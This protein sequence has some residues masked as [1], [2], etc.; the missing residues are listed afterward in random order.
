M[1]LPPGAASPSAP[2]PPDCV[3]V[4]LLRGTR[5]LL[6]LADAD[7]TLRW[8]NPAL[9]TLIGRDL[10]QLVG[11]TWPEALP[12]APADRPALDRLAASLA[13]RAPTAQPGPA[14]EIE[15]ELLPAAAAPAWLRIAAHSVLNDA[16]HP[17]GATRWLLVMHDISQTRQSQREAKRLSGLLDMAQEFGRI[18]VWERDIPSGAGRW[19][20][21]VFDFYGLDPAA[22]TPTHAEAV[23]HLHPDDRARMNYLEST[24]R[25]GR[26]QLRYR[27]LHANG[28]TRWIQSQWEVQ[29]SPAGVPCRAVGILMDDSEVVEQA[30]ALGAPGAQLKLAIDL[31]H[32]AIWRHDLRTDRVHYNDDAQRVLAFPKSPDGLSLQET[33]DRIHPDDVG[34]VASAARHALD[35]PDRPTDIEARFNAGDGLWRTLLTRRVLERGADGTPSAWV[36]IALDVSE[37]ADERRRTTAL[38]Q[39]MEAAA[40]AASVGIWSYDTVTH[41]AQWNEPMFALVGRSPLLGAPSRAE[42]DEQVIHPA[43][44]D[45]MRAERAVLDARP[46][47]GGEQRYRVALPGGE[48][49]WLENRVRRETLDGHLTILGVTLD[50]TDRQLAEDA[51]R[52]ADQ[53]AA[54]AAR[55]AGIGTW[56]MDFVG[57]DERWDEQMYR[58]RGLAPRNRPLA[59]AERLALLHPDDRQNVFDSRPDALTNRLPAQYEFRVRWPDG[60]YRWL[61]SRS[62][63]VADE[64][65]RPLRR[66]GV[67]WDITDARLAEAAREQ[68]ALAQRENL[69]KSRFLSRVSHELRTPLNAVIGFAQ[70]V[71]AE[72]DLAP[73]QRARLGWI[74][75][76]GEHLLLLIDDVLDLSGLEIGDLKLVSQAV[77]L[78]D[79]VHETL[80]LVEP[81]AAQHRIALT[82]DAAAGVAL[83]DR[84][85]LRQ[86]LIN[87]LSNGIKYNRAQGQVTVATGC[88]GGRVTLQVSDTGRGLAPEQLAHLFEPFNRLGAERD[89]IDGSGIGLVIVKALVERMGGTVQVS[90]RLGEGTQ[91]S[92]ELPAAE[93]AA[94]A[95]P[96]G[97]PAA[98]ATPL[99]APA[100]MRPGRLLYI[101]DNPVNMLLVQELVALRPVIQMIVATTGAQGV[102]QAIA[103]RPELVLVDMQL[104]DFDGFE[105]LRRLR[106][107]PRTAELRCVALSANA[108]PD[109][110]SRALDA[111]FADYWTKPIH[112]GGFLAALDTVFAAAPA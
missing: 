43:D 36:G 101:E 2:P 16:T 110:I 81:L 46:G 59:R 11:L 37:H 20:H 50:I 14:G 4:T 75:S 58:L 5:D 53:R 17:S 12:V 42:W 112:F 33:R 19:D 61:A 6:L 85:R 91:F 74:R 24:H 94:H 90:S 73:A 84:T 76:A 71:Q 39:R 34:R 29:N 69:A 25:A 105:V 54:L 3:G 40:A 22:G 32:I 31:G 55:G 108:L 52:S 15:I 68:G 13:R 49:R 104:P 27:I 26:Y 78:A 21:H 70:L 87:L 60:S 56:A 106:A 51:L 10:S 67:N 64:T 99:A 38:M 93:G 77:P 63:V 98:A 47:A 45:R 62:T 72:A 79:L 100:L 109:D 107:D 88:V 41:Q 30:R 65:G 95:P 86:V 89:G 9:E 96:N 23:M 8:C 28:T 48:V 103:F 18:G 1:P 66:I 83:A 111:G 102:Q 7:A 44:R 80:P 82:V 92:I 97:L 35:T 57:D